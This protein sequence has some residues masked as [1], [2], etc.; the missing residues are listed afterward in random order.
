M[1]V[2]FGQFREPTPE[3]LRFSAQFG[4][5]DVL[6]NNANLPSAGGRWQLHDLVRL[7]LSVEQHGLKLSAMENVPTTFYDHI[8]L[9]GPKRDEQIENM[10]FTIRN[11]AR[12]GIPVI[13]PI[14]DFKNGNVKSPSPQIKDSNLLVTFLVQPIG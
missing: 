6:F 8:M 2:G 12:A 5:T 13:D 10:I 7:R 14:A 9:A 4:A 1:R 3:Y 11:I